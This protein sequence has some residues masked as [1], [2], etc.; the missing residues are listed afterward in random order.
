MLAAENVKEIESGGVAIFEIRKLF[1]E[2][3]GSGRAIAVN[4]RHVAERLGR[5]RGLDDG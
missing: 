5:K 2:K 4:E 3:N 1:A